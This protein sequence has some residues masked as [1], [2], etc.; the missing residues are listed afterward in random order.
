M[1]MYAELH[2]GRKLEFPDGTD[3]AVIQATVK[4]TL[5]LSEPAAPAEPSTLQ[6]I[7]DVARH[8]SPAGVAGVGA[9]RGV[10]DVI[11]T[12]ADWLSRGFD[13]LTGSNQNADVKAGNAAGNKEFAAAA[14]GNPELQAGRMVGQVAATW[15]VG[16][17][18]AAPVKLAARAIP[19]LA[20][21]AEAIA[22]GG[23]SAGKVGPGIPAAVANLATRATGGAIT[24][25]AGAGLVNPDDAGT[26]AAIGAAVPVVGKVAGMAGDAVGGALRPLFNSGQD[27]VV[28]DTLR[29]FAADPAAARTSLQGAREVIPGSAPTAVMASGDEGLAGLSRTM[30]S[31]NPAYANELAS[32]MNAQNAARTTAIEGI[33]GNPGKLEAAKAARDAATDAMRESALQA[34]G[35]IEANPVLSRLD[36]MLTNPNN[37]GKFSQQAIR[38]VR[39]Q[40]AQFVGE[41]GTINARA[42]YEIRKD[43][44]TALSGKLQG[45]AGN[46]KHAASQLID[47]KGLIDNAIDQAGRRV[48]PVTGTAVMP[49]GSNLARAGEAPIPGGPRTSWKQYL[50][51]YTKQSVP[52]NQMELL[53]DVMKRVQTGTVDKDGHMILS[54]AKLNTLLKTDGQDLIK[55]LAPDQIDLLRRLAADLN[56]SQ[57]ATNS[58]KAAGSNT[59]QNLASNNLLQ[60]TLGRQLGG[61]SPVSATAGR[62]LDWLYKRPNQSINDKLGAALLDPQEAARLMQDPAAQ[63]AIARLFD[64]SG[65]RQLTYRAAPL[66]GVQR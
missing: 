37:A 29:K 46:V 55:K 31:A 60:S 24:G 25:G 64:Q 58:G 61:S 42:L 26:G 50:D 54:A 40:I 19:G 13:K 2:D 47:A 43:I 38:N 52:I 11:D 20:P 9:A 30:Q 41:D 57:L 22:T 65:A 1:P 35:N 16:G 6:T 63:S 56:A 14:A 15:P 53:D 7:I 23:A 28:G 10:K 45:E 36:S 48:Q 4:K 49:G 32:R 33:A 21:L 27:R 39:E 12:G 34:A 8:A 44:N 51:E 5:G 66:V 3:P 18:I 62:A 59:V 17:V